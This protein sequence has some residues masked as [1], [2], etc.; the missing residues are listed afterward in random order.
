MSPAGSSVMSACQR[1]DEPASVFLKMQVILPYTIE[2]FTTEV[3][4]SFKIGVAAASSAGCTC[5]I[6]K[7][8][9]SITNL[10][11]VQRRVLV[12]RPPT[13]VSSRRATDGLVVD[14]S[15]ALLNS[16]Q[17]ESLLKSGYLSKDRLNAELEK[18]G[19]FPISEISKRPVIS[20]PIEV[21]PVY[22]WAV[23]GTVIGVLV[24]AIFFASLFFFVAVRRKRINCDP[25]GPVDDISILMPGERIDPDKVL[26]GS[27]LGRGASGEV[28]RGTYTT[29]GQTTVKLAEQS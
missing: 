11:E 7:E 4:N 13:V 6:A 26:F 12:G 21:Q 3:Q 29:N 1:P 20:P 9:V 22:P 23:V 27:F 18:V 8:N 28:V 2:T 15:I 14:L 17:G 10:V 24:F 16:E 5:L 25:L 19:V